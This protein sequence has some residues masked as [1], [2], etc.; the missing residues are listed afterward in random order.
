[1]KTT[2]NPSSPVSK[3]L[4]GTRA[5]HSGFTLIELMIVVAIVAI[6]AAIAYPAYTEQTKKARRSEARNL[7]MDAASRQEQFFLDN[8]AYATAMTS[9]GFAADP[10]TTEGG[11]YR[12]SI[13]AATADC[14]VTRCFVLRATPQGAQEGDGIM[15]V[16]SNGSQ[17]WDKN[18]DGDTADAGEDSWS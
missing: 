1:M 14:P 15:E 17:R 10:E 7:L 6:L 8:R 2:A 9:L 12:V 13:V 16:D 5:R 3:P 11:F 18:N 4:S